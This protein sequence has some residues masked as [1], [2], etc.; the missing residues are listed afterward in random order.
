MNRTFGFE[1]KRWVTKK[2]MARKYF[3]YNIPA[4]CWNFFSLFKI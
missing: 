3:E 2:Q 4:S 1:E